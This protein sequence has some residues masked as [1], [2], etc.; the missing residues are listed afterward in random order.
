MRAGAGVDAGE[1]DLNCNA[2]S[3]D[4]AQ[5][6]PGP[7]EPLS[8]AGR[9]DGARVHSRRA[10]HKVKRRRDLRRGGVQICR[11]RRAYFFFA[12]FFGAAFFAV[13]FAFLAAITASPNKVD[14]QNISRV[15]GNVK[16]LV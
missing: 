10:T 15:W 5:R 13:F 9:D 1:A 11:V 12:F 6:D 14:A 4:A 8:G 7:N 2:P 3:S 16:A